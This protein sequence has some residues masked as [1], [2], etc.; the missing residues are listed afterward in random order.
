MY[1]YPCPSTCKSL[2]IFDFHP[3]GVL[4]ELDWHVERKNNQHQDIATRCVPPCLFP[5]ALMMSES[6]PRF[7]FRF[8]NVVQYHF[9]TCNF[10]QMMMKTTF[11]R[12]CMYYCIGKVIWTGFR[13]SVES[14]LSNSKFLAI[15]ELK[16]KESYSCIVCIFMTLFASWHMTFLPRLSG[17]HQIGKRGCW[18]YSHIF[19][20]SPVL[21]KVLCCNI[22]LC[23]QFS[24]TGWYQ[25]ITSHDIDLHHIDHDWT[26]VWQIAAKSLFVG[27]RQP[28]LSLKVPI[29]D[30]SLLRGPSWTTVVRWYYFHFHFRFHFLKSPHRWPL[31]IMSA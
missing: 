5:I 29:V 8:L 24:A 2:F 11:K 21:S 12:G 30:P 22:S 15:S 23:G 17:R 27:G 13:S 10:H 14:I 20:Q 26:Y 28:V 7:H 6:D 31:F 18:E 4:G 19:V 16:H 25:S 9:S 1:L 3:A